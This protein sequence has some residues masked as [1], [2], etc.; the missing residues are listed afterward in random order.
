LLKAIVGTIDRYGLRKR[1]LNKHRAPAERFCD[2]VVARDLSSEVAKNYVRRIAK[3]RNH[4]F[5]FL[6]YDGVPWNNNNAEH[7]IKSFAKFRRFSNGTA[8]E[9]TVKD[10]L[11][12]LSVCLTCECRG[13]EFLNVLL[14][15]TEGDFGFGPKRF[16][17][18]RLRPP[19]PEHICLPGQRSLKLRR[20]WMQFRQRGRHLMRGMANQGSSP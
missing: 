17:P 6:A 9:D 2:W 4:L 18:L 11:L 1:H 10:Y 20:G 3:Y 7:A 12:I 5:A 8:T 19:R 15:K 14:G 16:T 13:I